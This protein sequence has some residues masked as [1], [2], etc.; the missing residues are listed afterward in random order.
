VIVRFLAGFRINFVGDH[1]HGWSM[2]M[3]DDETEDADDDERER[4]LAEG[5]APT[6]VAIAGLIAGLESFQAEHP[7]I[8]D[9]LTNVIGALMEADELLEAAPSSR[10]F[11][12]RS[13]EEVLGFDPR[14]GNPRP[15]NLPD[16]P[17]LDRRPP[18]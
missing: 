2:N 17:R 15:R 4:A 10:N 8:A 5:L 1:S 13:V 9:G 16:L 12:P 6:R 3:A 7:R 18:K 14:D 11:R